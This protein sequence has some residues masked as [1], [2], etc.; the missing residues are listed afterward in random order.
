MF[1]KKVINDQDNCSEDIE[2]S[3]DE[4]E[5]SNEQLIELGETFEIEDFGE[6]YHIERKREHQSSFGA[7]LPTAAVAV[8]SACDPASPLPTAPASTISSAARRRSASLA[9]LPEPKRV[10]SATGAR[11]R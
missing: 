6:N 3:I 9:A 10:H 11:H 2:A 8:P 5:D 4:E 1:F 7:Q